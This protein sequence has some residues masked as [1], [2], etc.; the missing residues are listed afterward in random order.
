VSRKVS[1]SFGTTVLNNLYQDEVGL[2][3]GKSQM[4]EHHTLITPIDMNI[5]RKFE[6]ILHI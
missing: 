5:F 6:V 1:E 3:K 2:Q 4:T